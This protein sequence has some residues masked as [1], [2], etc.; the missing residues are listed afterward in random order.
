MGYRLAGGGGGVERKVFT[1][2]SGTLYN[3]FLLSTSSTSRLSCSI[4]SR[5]RSRSIL[6]FSFSKYI[7]RLWSRQRL[8]PPSF[9]LKFGAEI[10]INTLAIKRPATNVRR[11]GTTRWKI[12]RY[13]IDTPLKT[14]LDCLPQSDVFGFTRVAKR[15]MQAELS[16]TIMLT[17][18]AFGEK[19]FLI[20]NVI[21]GKYYF[22]FALP[23]DLVYNLFHV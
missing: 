11:K 18:F 23:G 7:C 5:S 10:G 2:P 19:L 6:K 12:A 16:D 20:C 21:W 13:D 9:I 22:R 8:P 14:S 4:S 17:F 15:T 3:K 1:V